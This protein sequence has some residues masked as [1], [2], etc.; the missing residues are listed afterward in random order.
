[1][2]QSLPSEQPAAGHAPAPRP[3]RPLWRLCLK[4]LF[5]LALALT[6]LTGGLLAF[7]HTERGARTAHYVAVQVFE[8]IDIVG[9]KLEIDELKGPLPFTLT[10]SGIRMR[11]M[12]GEW[13]R[14]G[15]VHVELDPRDFFAG[16]LRGE[17]FLHGRTVEVSDV[18]MP[19]IPVFP[20]SPQAEK[21]APE[22]PAAPEM[23]TLFPG[24]LHILA[25]NVSLHNARVDPA[26]SY[27]GVF[28]HVRGAARIEAARGDARLGLACAFP[29]D[30]GSLRD[31][32]DSL[33]PSRVPLEWPFPAGTS[34]DSTVID[35]QAA[36]GGKTKAPPASFPD[37][38]P[39]T[40]EGS[41]RLVWEGARF[42][43]TLEATDNA[44][45]RR[46]A[47]VAQTA[48]FRLA[49]HYSMPV[50]PPIPGQGL[51]LDSQLEAHFSGPKL[52]QEGRNLH[53]Q[54]YGSY[55]GERLRMGPARLE[56]PDK[57][58]RL[59]VLV[60]GGM[61]EE[62]NGMVALG[63]ARELG[64]LLSL[65][66]PDQRPPVSGGFNLC[67][68]TGTGRDWW[69]DALEGED[70]LSR[71]ALACARRGGQ[72]KGEEGGRD[73]S[74]AASR[75]RRLLVDASSA[76]LTVPGGVIGRLSLN[77]GG[78]GTGEAGLTSLLPALFSGSLRC[79]AGNLFGAGEADASFRWTWNLASGKESGT[80]D[81]LSVQLPGFSLSGG[82]ST[83]GYGKALP[84]VPLL[85]GALDAAVTNW[86]TLGALAGLERNALNGGPATA[87]IRLDAGHQ[88]QQVR[89]EVESHGFSCQ[90]A[91]LSSLTLHAQA[92]DLH[93]LAAMDT[94]AESPLALTLRA[95]SGEAGGF[96]W[97]NVLLDA[98]SRHA[99][100]DF[101]ARLEGDWQAAAAGTL[102]RD[103]QEL[104]LR[105]CDV[106]HV[107]HGELVR[108]LQPAT[109]AFRDGI[110]L[111][112]WRM[113]IASQGTLGMD[114]T[115]TDATLALR[116]RADRL[117]LGMLRTLLNQPILPDADINADINFRGSP[118]HP[119][120]TAMLGIENIRQP[121]EQAIPLSAALPSAI[122]LHGQLGGSKGSTLGLRLHVD[123]WGA[124]DGDTFRAV[125]GIPLHFT[126]L[127]SPDMDK[128]ATAD[129]FWRGD[130]EKLWRY[131]PLPG[132]SLSGRGQAEARLRGT[133]RR[134]RLEASVFLA[135][136]RYVDK[137]AGVKLQNIDVE[138]RYSTQG[139]SLLRMQ[140]RDTRRGTLAVNAALSSD[141]KLGPFD[142]AG[143]RVRGVGEISRL[144]PLHRDDLSMQLSGS[145]GVEG[146]LAAPA[147]TG[148]VRL[149]EVVYTVLGFG[150][151]S[152]TE[153]D[154]V[155]QTS[156]FESW[157][158][159]V[160]RAAAEATPAARGPALD[161]RVRAPGKVFIRGHGL[162]SEWK[163]DLHL[164]GPAS[165]PQL[166][167]DVSPVRGTFSL[168]GKEFQFRKG[169]IRF[170]G[171]WP[172]RPTL[173]L[174][175]NYQARNIIAEIL[176]QGSAGQPKLDLSSQPAMPRDEVMAQILFDKSASELNRFQIIQATNAT[177]NLISGKKDALDILGNT[178]D[179]LGF[180]VLR[181]GSGNSGTRTKSAPT[182]A[183]VKG[184]EKSDGESA[185]SLEAGKY[186][187]DNVYVG[188][189]QDTA[190]G[191][192]TVRVDVDVLPNISVT[193]R[194]SSISSNVGVNWK[195]DY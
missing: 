169:A 150:G 8:W 31:S 96:A 60:S 82:I 144:R 57:D 4:L 98:Q 100:V 55:D 81:Q 194:T 95:G 51:A 97:N 86:A 63:E 122:R 114:A 127:P 15:R 174:G 146:P 153:L 136:G 58:T 142:L 59:R 116:A 138:A 77:A 156:S 151:P 155:V 180:E 33:V 170:T 111:S 108:L 37:A 176:V 84:A 118:Q 14:V 165:R 56:S 7:L 101:S 102:R 42:G 71:A 66:N 34:P 30:K 76:A 36:A 19:R 126:P 21:P 18:H 166:V 12:E 5:C 41:L 9:L 73:G 139:T 117:P 131:L 121:K 182:D 115:F 65:L 67:A 183:S 62:G 143:L 123:G 160:L 17:L 186:L 181:V 179:L 48:R 80:L 106:R 39:H 2:S 85:R 140:A 104:S 16:L 178:R 3:R 175:L 24:W 164:S 152:V 141:P 189:E 89:A 168:L 105:Q 195:M 90:A 187:F 161:L 91:Q 40:V 72:V 28:G 128:A 120:G 61:G 94:R 27:Y 119:S 191:N 87:H 145:I 129:I 158:H 35:A 130:V 64:T 125:A 74:K 92:E 1:M 32:V 43:L 157:K 167:G 79:S 184:K 22:Q 10:A 50:V 45:V 134:P 93:S 113:N 83:A 188:V 192:T 23:F 148:D 69:Q 20:E 163:A 78:Q 88:R 110:S 171:A 109:L 11:D 70:D 26:V 185:P 75:P 173:D 25:D 52:P 49:A 137:L 38:A 132:R 46:Y 107:E 47:P 112:D 99:A 29:E 162:D 6:V 154:A 103:R 172:P 54:L 147:I 135:G 124:A 133:L 159:G 190:H 68:Y 13:L 177:R 193:G 44:F 53:V 149:D